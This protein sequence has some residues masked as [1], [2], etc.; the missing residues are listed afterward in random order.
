MLLLFLEGSPLLHC[1]SDL[2]L[3]MFFLEPFSAPPS[4]S[5]GT[6]TAGKHN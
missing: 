5:L 2:G 3:A 1:P 6:T 4:S